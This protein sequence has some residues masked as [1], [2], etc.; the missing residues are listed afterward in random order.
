MRKRLFVI[1]LI[2]ALL[3]GVVGG[4]GLSGYARLTA[5]SRAEARL[6]TIQA[7]TLVSQSLQHEV[8][9]QAWFGVAIAE[10]DTRRS[11][12]EVRSE[13]DEART[14]MLATNAQLSA[15]TDGTVYEAEL[16]EIGA[17]QDRLLGRADSVIR[18]SAADRPA[19]L[20]G[21]GILEDQADTLNDQ[22]SGLI[23]KLSA[24]RAEQLAAAD[25]IKQTDARR[26]LAAALLA[27]LLVLGLSARLTRSILRDLRAVD[28][29]A[30]RVGAGDLDARVEKPRD[31]EIGALARSFNH[32]AERLSETVQQLT[33]E[34]RREKLGSQLADAF[35]MAETEHD[36]YEVVANTLT[37][38]GP[39]RPAELLLADHSEARLT[40]RATGRTS[41]APC[42]PVTSPFHCVAVRRGHLVSFDDSDALD[43]CP[44]LRNRPQG[45]V[46][47]VCVP[48]TFMGRSLGVVHT[49]GPA[50]RMPAGEALAGLALLGAQAGNRIGTLRSFELAQLQASTDA[51]TGLPNRRAFES[52]ARERLR[53]GGRLAFVMADLDKFK[54]LN[55]AHGHEAGDRAL[56]L[57]ARVLR[58]GLGKDD[59]AG[60][61]GGEEF[62]MVLSEVTVD[63]AVLVL[64]RI[65]AALSDAIDGGTPRFTASFGVCGNDGQ[66]GF[67]DLLRTADKALYRAK[68]EGRDRVVAAG[69][70]N[71]DRQPPV[72]APAPVYSPAG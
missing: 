60:R 25:R 71:H 5:A 17:A 34:A 36:A 12:V 11:R 27:A 10:G 56:R 47:A 24:D 29:V 42:C 40:T 39:D 15:L 49:T 2:G 20:T 59:L 46:S 28:E 9:A 55:D 68:R 61:L 3:T 18:L 45:R 53:G 63:R 26:L 41:E 54:L 38:L 13:F 70:P 32:T 43:A 52:E 14:T 30:H 48:V 33:A 35:D 50:G 65:R 7:L 16:R 37:V 62:G 67:E 19:A 57:F 23:E 22:I 31:D 1:A 58:A 51:L 6:G 64:D 72:E 44:K 66:T 8:R 21:I 4:V 69:A